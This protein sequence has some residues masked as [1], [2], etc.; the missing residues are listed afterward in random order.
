MPVQSTRRPL[1]S[2]L[3]AA[4]SRRR[5]LG[6]AA[7]VLVFALLAWQLAEGDTVRAGGAIEVVETG[8]KVGVSGE[9]ALTLTAEAEAEIVEVLFYYRPTGGMVWNYLYPDFDAGTRVTTSQ[10]LPPNGATYLAPGVD[11]EYYYEIHDALG[12]VLTT[13]RALVEYL[14]RRFDWQR[15]QVGPLTLLYHDLSRSTVTK[16]AP[17]IEQD[18]D[19]ITGL[20]RLTAPRGIKGVIYNR[21]S[22]AQ[23]AFP[24]ESQTTTDQ[25][26]FA[27]FALA[28]QG[29][30]VGLG[31]D[32]RIIAH[33]SAH[34]LFDQAVAG[35]I[36]E[37][38]A[39]LGEGFASYFEPERRL[40]S[41]RKIYDRSAP[42]KT[43]TIVSG[44]PHAI[45]LF[46]EK[47][48]SVVTYLIDE[49]GESKFQLFI[50][51]LNNDLE[52]DNALESVYGFDSDGLEARWAGLDI[53]A[54]QAEAESDTRSPA[55]GQSQPEPPPEAENDTQSSAA[56]GSRTEAGSD[57]QSSAAG[58]SQPET[59]PEPRRFPDAP[60][61]PSPFAFFD[62]WLFIGVALVVVIVVVARSAWRKLRPSRIEED[63]PY[64]D[65]YS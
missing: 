33:E 34:L 14:D 32:R 31:L 44:T 3:L 29:V 55:T 56:E 52:I 49:H 59:P 7:A 26:V 46:Y 8:A 30:F 35:R 36:L 51:A 64:W 18:L 28:E 21:N 2:R 39:W 65:S 62:S 41:P 40:T 9:V 13:D 5:V 24:R 12:N 53:A 63:S 61:S 42:L 57:A 10:T 43:M 11:V 17:V 58:G 23:A 1:P 19:R 20:L 47:A 50:A 27:G 22:D 15:A 60:D 25:A 37:I 38:P 45:H 4:P 6:L 48:R 16:A 54:I